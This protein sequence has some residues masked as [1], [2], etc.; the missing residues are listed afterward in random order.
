M[1][2][3]GGSFNLGPVAG[4]D[5]EAYYQVPK[6]SGKRALVEPFKYNLAGKEILQ[7]AV[8]VPIQINGRFVGVAGIGVALSS[9]QELAQTL[10][11][12][13]QAMPVSCPMAGCF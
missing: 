8:A 5:T 9:L 12:T 10:P 1:R 6:T 2:G 13:T 7:T 3:E 4:Y 11:C